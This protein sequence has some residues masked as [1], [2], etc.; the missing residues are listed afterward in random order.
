MKRRTFLATGGFSALHLFVA[1]CKSNRGIAPPDI[2]PIP[3]PQVTGFG[4]LV[5]HPTLPFDVPAGFSIAMIQQAMAPMS[6]GHKMPGQPDGMACFEDSTGSWILLRNHELSGEETLTRWSTKGNPFETSAPPE[7]RF[8]E[9]NFGGVSLVEIHPDTINASLDANTGDPVELLASRL[10][11]SGTDGN[12]AGGVVDNAWVSCEESSA[13]GHGYAFVTRPNDQGLEQ[14]RPVKSWGRFHREAVARDTQTG[15]IYMTEDRSDGL[16]YRFIPD[17]NSE[18]FGSGRLQALK[19]PE[20]PNTSPYGEDAAEAL[21]DNGQNWSVEW[22]DIPDPSAAEK[23]CRSQGQE[24][25]ATTFQRGEGIYPD[26]E[27]VWFIA[28]TAG[29]K[30]G[31]QIFLYRPNTNRLELALEVDDRSLLSC[32]DNLCVAP[33]GDLICT[34]D[35]YAYAEGVTHQHV[36]GLTRDGQVYDILRARDQGENHPGPEFTGPCFSP[37]GSVLFVNVQRPLEL[38]LAIRG[39]WPS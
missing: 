17:D 30:G 33:W 27:G 38:T 34:E 9:G 23:T 10:V 36:R 25:G 31:G 35:N 32:P 15:A 5:E 4:P 8:S 16:F 37:D 24:A 14:P 28:S 21:W 22:V 39:P 1:A 26:E 13:E 2:G 11:L 18:P 3:L 7:P 12:C 29:H 19:I 6:D 20:I